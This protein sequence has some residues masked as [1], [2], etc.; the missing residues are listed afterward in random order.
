MVSVELDGNYIDAEAMKSRKSESL[1]KA[2]KA[3]KSRW[4]ATGVIPLNWH[5]LDNV[6][7]E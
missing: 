5:M 7:P 2:Y 4:D 6:A 3:I 1:T